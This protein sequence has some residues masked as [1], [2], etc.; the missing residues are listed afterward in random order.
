MRKAPLSPHQ[1]L[2][3]TCSAHGV[4]NVRHPRKMSVIAFESSSTPKIIPRVSNSR[5]TGLGVGV[6]VL[7]PAALYQLQPE[8]VGSL[9]HL[10]RVYESLWS[11]AVVYSTLYL[12]FFI[13]PPSRDGRLEPVGFPIAHL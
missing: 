5:P 6:F 9:D 3:K 4:N 10:P 1:K 7:V 13:R 12:A 8:G 11:V 2:T